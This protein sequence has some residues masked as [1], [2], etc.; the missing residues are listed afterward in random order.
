MIRSAVGFLEERSETAQ[1]LQLRA[2]AD[3]LEN[4]LRAELDFEEEATTRS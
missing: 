1:L 2:L 3:E 4:H